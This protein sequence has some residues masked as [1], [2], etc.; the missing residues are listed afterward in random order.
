V[1]RSCRGAR[2]GELLSID[3]TLVTDAATNSSGLMESVSLHGDRIEMTLR[4]L[5]HKQGVKRSARVKQLMLV[6][7][8]R[9]IGLQH[10]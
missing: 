5:L 2:R 3:S 4:L 10:P 7:R 6:L 1:A 9:E 8:N